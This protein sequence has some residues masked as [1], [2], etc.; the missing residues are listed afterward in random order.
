MKSEKK[1]KLRKK[2]WKVGSTKELLGLTDAE[3]QLIELKLALA[4]AVA[5]T[6]KKRRLTQVQVAKL[7]ESSQS[8]VAKIEA[9]DASVSMD[10]LVRTLLAL[11]SD[12]KDVARVIRAA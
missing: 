9:G 1:K 10:L 3:E 7:I 4:K 11:G 8:R 5:Q 6:R 12:N 2:G